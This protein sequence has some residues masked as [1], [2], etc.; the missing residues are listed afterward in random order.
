[1]YFTLGSFPISELIGFGDTAYRGIRTSFQSPAQNTPPA[2]TYRKKKKMDYNWNEIL[3]RKDNYELYQIF[4]GNTH[5]P[6]KVKEI[7]KKEFENRK[8][9]FNNIDELKKDK[10]IESLSE[11]IHSNEYYKWS[12]IIGIKAYLILLVLLII[13]YL[14]NRHYELLEGFTSEIFVY[15]FCIALV[16]ILIE[17]LIVNIR[18][19]RKRKLIERYRKINEA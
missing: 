9:N 3:S 7:A 6:D 19:G 14:I 4:I 5:L 8:F 11:S 10:K 2:V 12:S 16:L 17:L 13:G 15:C 18:N 1:M